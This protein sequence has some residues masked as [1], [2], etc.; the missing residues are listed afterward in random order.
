MPIGT[1]G[2]L[3]LSSLRLVT[4]LFSII[5]SS[6]QKDVWGFQ[7]MKGRSVALLLKGLFV[8]MKFLGFKV[9]ND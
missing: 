6:V 2:P 8:P 4:K 5:E 9:F 7:K 1:D 3:Q